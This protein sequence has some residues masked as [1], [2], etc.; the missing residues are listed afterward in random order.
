MSKVTDWRRYVSI[1]GDFELPNYLYNCIND[2]MKQALDMGTLLSDDNTKLRAYKEQV[3][4]LFKSRWMEIAQ[5]FETF[6][7]LVP[8]VCRPTD[9]CEI[10]GGSRYVFNDALSPD[11]IKQVSYAVTSSDMG[12]QN[13]LQEGL[14]RALKEYALLVAE[15]RE[16]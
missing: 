12:L 7:L 16:S 3:K 10:C 8:C 13:K 9:Y 5:V 11:Q 1:N 15:T 6:D 14:E 4:H 2:L